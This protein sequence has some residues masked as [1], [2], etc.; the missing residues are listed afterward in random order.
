MGIFHAMNFVLPHHSSL[1]PFSPGTYDHHYT[2][3]CPSRI[4]TLISSLYHY[5]ACVGVSISP[6]ASGLPRFSKCQLALSRWSFLLHY[7]FLSL[8]IFGQ[9]RVVSSHCKGPPCAGL[10]LLSQVLSITVPFIPQGASSSLPHPVF[11]H[12][13]LLYGSYTWQSSLS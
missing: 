1:K 13:S 10:C 5:H 9:H 2:S 11:L 8:Q 3:Y 6:T 4:K 7:A 12:I